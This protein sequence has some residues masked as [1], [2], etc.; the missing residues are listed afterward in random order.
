MD[1]T[2]RQKISQIIHKITNPQDDIDYL[3]KTYLKELKVLVKQSKP[4]LQTAFDLLV[5]QLHCSNSKIRFLTLGLLS[6]LCE[7]SPHLREE[8]SMRLPDI[9][10]LFLPLSLT[11]VV[12][13]T[14]AVCAQ[15]PPPPQFASKLLALGHTLL[16][17]WAQ[18]F[19]HLPNIHR[20]HRLL[21]TP[22]VTVT[23]S[24]NGIFV[25]FS[26]F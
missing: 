15:L 21:T 11:K 20:A 9:L 4:S 13:T 19:P 23:P 18:R 8:F 25:S 26:D 17:D 6:W 22:N 10:S 1:I 24:L 2:L 12:V 5:E 7:H 3:N 16:H 14:P